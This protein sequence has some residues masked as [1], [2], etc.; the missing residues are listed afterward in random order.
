MCNQLNRICMLLDHVQDYVVQRYSLSSLKRLSWLV[1]ATIGT[2]LEVVL[3]KV[4]MN[5]IECLGGMK[6]NV[7]DTHTHACKCACTRVEWLACPRLSRC[8]PSVWSARS[9]CA[10]MEHFFKSDFEVYSDKLCYWT[11]IPKL[12]LRFLMLFSWLY[13]LCQL[14]CSFFN[15][16]YGSKAMQCMLSTW[17]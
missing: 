11:C 13:K 7:T 16:F 9:F 8:L 3:G 14:I 1:A 15:C 6:T 2:G 12:P 5:E 17:S 4:S 10:L